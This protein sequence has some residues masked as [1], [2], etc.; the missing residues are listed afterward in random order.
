[1]FYPNSVLLKLM[2]LDPLS[3]SR[4]DNLKSVTPLRDLGSWGM[5]RPCFIVSRKGKEGPAVSSPSVHSNCPRWH[6]CPGEDRFSGGANSPVDYLP[7][8]YRYINIGPCHRELSSLTT[9]S[10]KRWQ[11]LRV[12]LCVRCFQAWSCRAGVDG[13]GFSAPL[14]AGR[15]VTVLGPR[16]PS[17]LAWPAPQKDFITRLT[18]C[19]IAICLLLS[20]GLPQM[21]VLLASEL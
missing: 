15:K 19:E 11:V 10:V 18:C 13:P 16:S 3:G 8:V 9:P 2:C 7:G 5:W 6:R 12:V 14:L 1:M 17:N 20:V 4:G 21:K